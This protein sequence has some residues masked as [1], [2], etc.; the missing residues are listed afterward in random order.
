MNTKKVNKRKEKKMFMQKD[1]QDLKTERDRIV[2]L[3]CQANEE[4][5]Y[6]ESPRV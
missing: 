1:S 4:A 2:A 3:A 6:V 5:D